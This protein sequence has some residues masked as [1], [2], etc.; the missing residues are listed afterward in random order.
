MRKTDEFDTE[1]FGTLES[2][3][4]TIAVVPGDRWWAATA[5]PRGRRQDKLNVFK[6]NILKRTYRARPNVGG[7]PTRRRN[8]APSRT[9]C[10]V[11]GRMTKAIHK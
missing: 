1:K 6:V 3:D 7:V 5:R 4:K 10:V 11:D 2:I 8:D 9:G